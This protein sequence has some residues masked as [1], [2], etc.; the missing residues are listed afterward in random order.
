MSNKKFENLLFSEQK[1]ENIS[2]TELRIGFKGLI[3]VGSHPSKTISEIS[4]YEQDK[5]DFVVS[6]LC[7]ESNK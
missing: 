4:F 7:S 6:L 3:G 1:F 5:T 2:V